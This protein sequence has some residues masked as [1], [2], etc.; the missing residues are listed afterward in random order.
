[1]S[2]ILKSNQRAKNFISQDLNLPADFSLSLNFENREYKAGGGV[3]VEAKSFMNYS[4]ANTATALNEGGRATYH[5]E[6]EIAIMNLLPSGETGLYLP[7]SDEDAFIPLFSS[8]MIG[9]E[10]TLSIPSLNWLKYSFAMLGTGKAT[11]TITPPTGVSMTKYPSSLPSSGKQLVIDEDNPTAIVFSAGGGAWTVRIEATG[12]VDQVFMTRK[13]PT[14]AFMLHETIQLVKPSETIPSTMR[15]VTS[16]L[17]ASMFNTL[18]ANQAKT[19]TLVFS[20]YVPF[21]KNSNGFMGVNPGWL[22]AMLF[23]DGSDVSFNG[24][25][26]IDKITR[27][28]I[29]DKT[30]GIEKAFRPMPDR[31]LTFALAFDNGIIR[32]ACNNKYYDEATLSAGVSLSAVDFGNGVWGTSQSGYTKGNLLIKQIYTYPRAL[33]SDELMEASALFM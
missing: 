3:P 29:Y 19:G 12:R 15:V 28:R 4:R 1:M 5:T 8:P 17:N 31:M 11:I 16:S 33:S 32:L 13:N 14:G 6:N 24:Y 22:M 9:G 25:T 23:S 18:F 10:K 7:S 26:D 30:T 20:F 27:Y 2:L 21:E